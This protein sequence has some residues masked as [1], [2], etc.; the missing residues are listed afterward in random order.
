MMY[1]LGSYQIERNEISS[2]TNTESVY[3]LKPPSAFFHLDD[4]YF[5]AGQVN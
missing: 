5:Y 2:S 3:E 4:T 1:P